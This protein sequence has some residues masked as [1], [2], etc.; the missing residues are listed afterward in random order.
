MSA[1]IKSTLKLYI[2]CEERGVLALNKIWD[3]NL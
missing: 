1:W 2:F 3:M